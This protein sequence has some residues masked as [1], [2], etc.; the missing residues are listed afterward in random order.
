MIF[1]KQAQLVL[2]IVSRQF[3][4]HP[5]VWP[6]F[7]ALFSSF[8]RETEFT[9][10]VSEEIA[11]ARSRHASRQ[12]RCGARCNRHEARAGIVALISYCL[13]R[14][15]NGG[16]GLVVRLSHRQ[17]ACSEGIDVALASCLDPPAFSG[18]KRGRCKALS[19]AVLDG[20]AIS[21]PEPVRFSCDQ[22]N[23]PTDKLLPSRPQKKPSPLASAS[24]LV[25]PACVADDTC[26]LEDPDALGDDSSFF[27]ATLC[28]ASLFPC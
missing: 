19:F 10:F 13:V 8:S 1:T 18:Y 20:T 7:F 5:S 11:T 21:D 6:M 16:L 15:S 26:S 2:A 24:P 22:R 14:L 28:T 4:R 23:G 27:A 17:C 25:L 9:K 12:R 3:P